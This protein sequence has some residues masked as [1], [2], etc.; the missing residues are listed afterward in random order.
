MSTTLERPALAT[1]RKVSPSKDSRTLL[2]GQ[3]R[4]GWALLAPALLHSGVFIVIPVI[5]VF[6]LSLTD[7]SFGDTWAWVGFRN[8]SD[9]FRDV[10]FQ[11]SLWHTVLYALVVIPI[12][13][14]I[15]LAV[16]I[17]LNQKIKAL[18][19]FRTAFYIPTVT[20]TVA[21]TVGM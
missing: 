20:A 3:A 17:G 6:V 14:A 19:F 16:A 12:S 9:L 10:D 1:P 15:S 8:Y 4:A 11:A 2:R 5:S 21:V 7:Y 18:G 13:M